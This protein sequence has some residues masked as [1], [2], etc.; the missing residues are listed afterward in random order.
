M[1][2]ERVRPP[3]T[4]E[5]VAD[6][7]CELGEGPVWHPDERRLYWVDITAGRLL[8]YDPASGESECVH[9][10]DVVSGLT[11]Q[12]DGS[13]LLFM[14]A[15]RVAHWRDGEVVAV[16][17]VTP[18]VGDSRFNDVIADPRGRVY[19][20]TMPTADRGGRFY[21]LD[22]DGSITRIE[23]DVDIPNGMGFTRDRSH[24]YFTE[25]EAATIY[26]YRYDEST[27]AL[28]DREAFVRS[29]DTPGLPDGMTVDAE[30]QLWSARW[31][32]GCVVQYD[33][34]GTEMERIDVPAA[35]VTSVAFGGP[36]LEQLYVTTAG[37]DD[38]ATEGRSA[39]G[40]FRLDPGVTGVEEFRSD[41]SL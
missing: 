29:P 8:L 16:S 34:A 30:G 25:T 2:A 33:A 39:G 17:T 10:T 40:L 15:G 26:R 1:T 11:I 13:L 32:G 4:L 19:C 41:V 36:D 9:E 28:S 38:R 6:H 22:T 35:K 21:R 23:D 24:L 20:G 3:M 7:Q 18:D 14:D 31:E 12:R 5:L 27:G 37:G